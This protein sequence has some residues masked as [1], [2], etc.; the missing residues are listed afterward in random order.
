MKKKYMSIILVSAILGIFLG[1]ILRES[2]KNQENHMS[3]DLFL[4]KE[5]K[6][7]SKSIKSLV[8]QKEKL[9]NEYEEL[10]IKNED[11]E[12]I[13]E[14]NNL[15][16]ILSYTD[17]KGKGI[18]IKID[19]LS[20]E[21]GNIAN[22]IDYNKIL[23]NLVNEL[24]LNGASY[25]SINNQRINQ[26]SEITLAG[27]HININSVPVAPPYEIK[28]IGDIEKLYSAYV[29]NESDYVR[30]M[31]KNYPLKIE[32]KSKDDIELE[33]MNVPNKLKYI[34]GE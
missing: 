12:K 3:K 16:E 6:A 14:V 25:I 18:I 22:F 30:S 13:N 7:I 1:G 32:I 8:K 17:I 24:K 4:K 23:I 26:Y 28:C 29:D 27:N 33:K 19:A 11:V 9:E 10:K 20:E 15:K 34:K 2:I 21:I 31:Q 5:V